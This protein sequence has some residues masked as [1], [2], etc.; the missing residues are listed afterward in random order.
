MSS[1]E[2]VDIICFKRRFSPPVSY[3]ATLVQSVLFSLLGCCFYHF[4]QSHL[5][6]VNLPSINPLWPTIE[7]VHQSTLLHFYML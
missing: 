3:P 2:S 5:F 4:D 1:S 7:Q 6:L